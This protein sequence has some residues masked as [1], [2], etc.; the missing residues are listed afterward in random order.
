MLEFSNIIGARIN[1]NFDFHKINAEILSLRSIWEEAPITKYWLNKAYAGEVFMSESQ[2][3]YDNVTHRY[4]CGEEIKKSIKEFPPFYSLYLRSH[5]LEEKISLKN[6]GYTK[7]LNHDTWQ[8]RESIRS[9]IPYTIACIESL[10]YKTVGIVR[11]LITEKTFLPTHIDCENLSAINDIGQTLGISIIS[12]TGGV[13]LK[14][15][16]KQDDCV[17]D[18]WGNTIIFKDSEAHAV[19]YTEDRR[20]TIRVFGDIDLDRLSSLVDEDSILL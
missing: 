11:V 20:I 19:P 13:P 7:Y 1:V 3:M 6:F 14:I 18:L 8:W 16:S 15:W 4:R 17:K 12:E 9:K 10:P 2:T 5:E